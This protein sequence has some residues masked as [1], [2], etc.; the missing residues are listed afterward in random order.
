M[1]AGKREKQ[2]KQKQKK[3]KTKTKNKKQKQT[4]L[5]SWDP[6]KTKFLHPFTPKTIWGET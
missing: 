5:I 1:L 3:K 2:K 6:K 4:N